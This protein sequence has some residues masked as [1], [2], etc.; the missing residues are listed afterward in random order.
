MHRDPV[1]LFKDNVGQDPSL[2]DIVKMVHPKPKDPNREALFGYFIGRDY[3][4]EAVPELVRNF[5][6]FKRGDGGVVPEVP[7]Q[8]LTALSLG[9]KEW[10]EIARRAPWQMTRMNLNTFARHGVFLEQGMSEV[11]ANRLRDSEKIRK[12]HI[13]PYQLMVAYSMAIA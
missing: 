9:T 1:T 4:V 7:F 13:F 5:E 11:I 6:A 8:M 2:A 12:A 3:N 10:I